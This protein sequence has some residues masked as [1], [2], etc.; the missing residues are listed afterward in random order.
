M[1]KNV[2]LTCAFCQIYEQF[3]VS[4]QLFF[5][6]IN[7]TTQYFCEIIIYLKLQLVLIIKKKDR[8][9]HLILYKH[10]FTKKEICLMNSPVTDFNT[11]RHNRTNCKT[12]IQCKQ[13]E[14]KERSVFQIRWFIISC[15]R[16]SEQAIP[17]TFRVKATRLKTIFFIWKKN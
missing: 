10:S 8:S 6:W 7:N 9:K 3:Q 4:L 11:L 14:K 2:F 16:V 12:Y 5:S 15:D 17:K 1:N 13:K